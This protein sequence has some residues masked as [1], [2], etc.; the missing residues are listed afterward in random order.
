MEGGGYEIKELSYFAALCLLV[1][2]G[3]LLWIVPFM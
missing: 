3:L 1:S 2:S